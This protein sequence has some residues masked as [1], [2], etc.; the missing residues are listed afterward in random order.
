M[1]M[2]ELE[3][4]KQLLTEIRDNQQ[5]SITK[6]E[7]HIALTQQH[8]DRAKSQVEESIGLQR[9]AI[10]KQRTITRIA[11]PGILVCILAILYLLVRYF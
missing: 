3:D 10:A 9:E 1:D 7:E 6:Q 8:L 2:S 11:I 5:H 4:I